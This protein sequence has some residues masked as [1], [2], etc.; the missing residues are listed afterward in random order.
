MAESYQR[1]WQKDQQQ[2][3]RAHSSAYV[4]SSS[5]AHNG[6]NT[7]QRQQ[8]RHLTR[9]SWLQKIFFALF[10]CSALATSAAAAG[11]TAAPTDGTVPVRGWNSWN[12]FRCVC[13]A[14]ATQTASGVVTVSKT[15][16]LCGCYL[17]FLCCPPCKYPERQTVACQLQR[18]LLLLQIS[19]S[20]NRCPC[21]THCANL[22]RTSLLLQQSCVKL[23]SACCT[24]GATSMKP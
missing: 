12:T 15:A 7:A 2:Q 21:R 14:T 16:C 6:Q 10:V 23:F 22:S 18:Q 11:N 9:Y 13:S 24:A 8:L 17:L 5:R 1:D 4:D 3:S 20:I 19:T